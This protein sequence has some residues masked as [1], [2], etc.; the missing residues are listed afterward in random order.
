MNINP[1]A[2]SQFDVPP[3]PRPEEM[4]D[5]HRMELNYWVD[6][7]NSEAEVLK[8][9]LSR[10]LFISLVA[11]LLTFIGYL[12]GDAIISSE[13][14]FGLLLIGPVIG[15]WARKFDPN[16]AKKQIAS[17][18]VFWL[19]ISPFLVSFVLVLIYYLGERSGGWLLLFGAVGLFLLSRHF[20]SH[21]ARVMS[22][23]PAN[24]NSSTPG[25]EQIPPPP[26]GSFISPLLWLI[27]IFGSTLLPFKYAMIAVFG[28]AIGVASEFQ[29]AKKKNGYPD[30]PS[31]LL[32]LLRA[33]YVWIAFGRDQTA[34]HPGVFAP[35][36]GMT[37]RI[38]A[39]MLIT[40]II[41]IGL[42]PSAS[43]F[44]VV[45]K[46]LPNQWLAD[47]YI[48]LHQDNYRFLGINSVSFTLLAEK[49][50]GFTLDV[51]KLKRPPP[52]H[53]LESE[54][55][56]YQAEFNAW[57]QGEI[58]RF[59]R[60]TPFGIVWLFID[61]GITKHSV[62][63][64]A[65]LLSIVLCFLMPIA[66][67]VT[68]FAL[69]LVESYPTSLLLAEEF[70]TP[71]GLTPEIWRK[72]VWRMLNSNDALERRHLLLGEHHPSR[73]PILLDQSIL[74]GHAYISGDTGS[75]KTSL[76]IM[77]LLTQ[78]LLKTNR[79]FD[80]TKRLD[81]SFVIIDLKG[82]PALFHT[83][84][85]LAEA[86]GLPFRWFTSES[87]RSSYAFNPLNQRAFN[88]LS[89]IAMTELQMAALSLEH[90]EGYGKSYFSRRA[91]NWLY[92]AMS[93]ETFQQKGK[94]KVGQRPKSFVELN[95]LAMN[96]MRN[97]N[98]EAK[99]KEHTFEILS[100]TST[101]AA[102]P[103]LNPTN[104][105]VMANAIDMADVIATPQVVYFWLPASIS[106]ASVREIGKLALYSLLAAAYQRSVSE[107]PMMNT[108]CFIDEFQRI[109]AENFKLIL[110]QAR[111]MRI[112]M[113]LSNQTPTDLRDGSTDYFPTIQGN[114]RFWQ[115]FAAGDLFHQDML[116]KSS[117]ETLRNMY[118]LGSSPFNTS[119]NG[120]TPNAMTMTTMEII[121]PL[122][123]KNHI[124][125]M[126][127]DDWANVV[128]IKR[129][130][131]YSRY[132]GYPL[133][134][135][136]TYSMSVEEY[137][138]RSR[139]PWPENNGHTVVMDKAA[140]QA[141]RNEEPNASESA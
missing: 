19:L 138:Q 91:R 42:L 26:V 140:A 72:Y 44:P 107:E 104:P 80:P 24:S 20:L 15:W 106:S 122:L 139:M 115:S 111:S 32:C 7:V 92:R 102:F 118:S 57:K 70:L 85:Q 79:Q 125:E 128:H 46:I 8:I 86:Q 96:F 131:G 75:G 60:E 45:Y 58:E 61:L 71:P 89:E 23:H 135:R 40:A 100:L 109:I 49:A 93:G 116:I 67:V 4:P 17:T 95:K 87:G 22:V 11:F 68:T 134:N 52:E 136:S 113:I 130:A 120:E 16:I 53:V 65:A 12:F 39:T 132:L 1:D 62:L 112:P 38:V 123:S 37:W 119:K 117:G 3:I 34:K 47:A 36:R 73:I 13:G 31:F 105:D 66:I 59:L 98:I 28:A 97:E 78:L 84:K 5:T 51:A 137:Q 9:T 27:A 14:F 88:E 101:L 63:L 121:R 76:G 90:G 35:P 127:D 94:S 81:A 2:A 77:P 25:D 48:D 18:K 10:Y 110:Q 124:L 133:L 99:E 108:Y 83:A 29:D 6:P 64:L 129:G 56:A 43:Y 21:I 30:W 114:T 54:Q 74:N 50:S 33:V 55:E 103:Q 69:S 82:D 126:T 41:S 141:E